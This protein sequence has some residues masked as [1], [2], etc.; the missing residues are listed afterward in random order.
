MISLNNKNNMSLNGIMETFRLWPRI[1]KILLEIDKVQVIII[2]LTTILNGIF[3]AII[4]IITQNLI[5]QVMY[6]N[7]QDF[8]NVLKYFIF[9]I[10]ITFLTEII[11][12]IQTYSQDIFR[13]ELAYKV[14]VMIMEKAIKLTLTDFENPEIYDKMQRAQEEVGFRPFSMYS[15]ILSV[16]GSFITLLSAAAILIVWKWWIMLLLFIIP[17][18]ST[19]YSTKI[20]KRQ[21]NIEYRRTPTYRKAWYYSF[22]MSRDINYKET[23][24]FGLE[25]FLLIKYKKIFERYL[26]VDKRVS[27][28]RTV[29]NFIFNFFINLMGD[30]ITLLIL[31]STFKGEIL[32]GNLFSYIRAVSMTESNFDSIMSTLFSM[33]QDNLYIRQLFE[34]LDLE[35]SETAL[36]T[37]NEEFRELN[38]IDK[39]EFR[40]VS[41][42]Y[43]RT[44][45]YALRYISFEIN[46]GDVIAMVGQNGSGKTTIVKLIARLYDNYEGS[47]LINNKNIKEYRIKDIR[48][49]MG[50]VFQDF[51]KYEM[52]VRH[53]IGFGN[54]NNIKNDFKILKS[55][56]DAGID[57]MINTFP[58]GIETQLGTWFNSGKQLSGGQ[59]QRIA[60]ARAFFRNASAYILDEPSSAL[61]PSAEKDIFERF[62]K[63][64][65]GKI[66]IFTSHRFST[67]KY[68]SKILVFDKGY[69]IEEGNHEELINYNKHYKKLYEIQASPFYNSL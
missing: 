4:L 54:V 26:K 24:L 22:L 52:K 29:V 3:P 6:N 45:D 23:K 50:I 11:T 65:S 17:V 67:V 33:Y 34:F 15:S 47:I 10:S 21:Y 62:F 19:L 41:F 68:A 57:N 31:F 18:I 49:K 36:F 59:W 20:G 55:T 8:S 5:N 9:L 14:N 28:L 40:N 37:E 16:I 46:K 2:T 69:I 30:G 13:I 43:P 53:N 61:D 38:S 58:E 12:S 1:F 25:S 35:E 64:T 39:I 42:R 44:Q 63:S 48:N 27:K 56:K 32:V 66:G 51:V 7:N 60:I